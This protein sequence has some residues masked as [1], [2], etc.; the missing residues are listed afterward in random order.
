[1]AI[2]VSVF[3][4]TRRSQCRRRMSDFTRVAGL[5]ASGWNDPRWHPGQPHVIVHF[6]SNDG[7]VMRLQF[8][9]VD[10]LA[11]TDVY[12]FPSRYQYIRV[13]RSLDE[14]SDDGRWLAGM[15]TRD[16]GAAVIFSLDIQNGALGAELPIQTIYAGDCQPDPEW[17]EVE[18]DWVDVSKLGAY[19]VIQWVRDGETRCS[20]LETFDIRTGEFIGRVTDHHHHVDLCVDYDGVTE[21]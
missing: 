19:L 13:P 16:D 2:I 17:G 3:I 9:D 6:D 18:P 21:I 10:A 14:I 12:T 11:T 8:T 1:M 5:D 4:L 7:S 20:G 15:A